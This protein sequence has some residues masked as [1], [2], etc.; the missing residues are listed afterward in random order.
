MMN[1]NEKLF[2]EGNVAKVLIKFSIPAILSMLVTELYNMV[3]TVFVGREVGGNAIG[4]LVVVFPIQRIVAA[5][6][7]M[8]AIGASTSVSRKK[9]KKNSRG[10]KKTIENA[11]TLTISILIPFMLLVYF[12]RTNILTFLGGSENIL[13]YANDYISV[14]IWGSIFICLTTV[15]NYIMMSLGNRKITM[16]S[17]SIGAITNTIVDAVLVVG[18]G[19]G[20]KGAAI[21]TLL[22]Q[23]LACMISFY[24]F[25]K[26]VI[27][28]Y[29]FK[30]NFK[31]EKIFVSTILLVGFSSFIVEAEDGI[32][33]AFLNNL[34]INN[35]GDEGVVILGIISKISMFMFIT[36][37]GMSSAMQP[38]AAYNL[39]AK[40]YERLKKVVKETV[41]FAFV[42]S[43]ILWGFL[44]YFAPQV[45]SIFVD[46]I[47]IINKSVSAFRTMVS[48][49]PIIS[50]YYVTIYYYQAINKAK[51]SFVISILRQII[52]MLPVSIIMVKV[53]N[54]GAYGVWLSYPISDFLAG[55]ISM[56]LI[57]KGIKEIDETEKKDLNVKLKLS[58]I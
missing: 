44:M 58:N 18:L 26:D 39:G 32:L 10:I 49:F 50:V 57:H 55:V 12:F 46:D 51:A 4:A 3:D 28:K 52:I 31:L 9:K 30:F 17:T 35:V 22:S 19:M 54:L 56:F 33:L 15:M 13:P 40:N 20:V 16:F 36:I 6:S 34:L 5:L 48:V 37:L 43:L 2:S 41:V 45:I 7:M 25:R 42:T 53:F 24:Q 47:N 23:I 29:D 1:E 8:L 21:A 14:I 38:I 27:K 11:I